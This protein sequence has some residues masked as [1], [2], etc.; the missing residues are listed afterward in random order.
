MNTGIRCWHL[1]TKVIRTKKQWARWLH[2]HVQS[3]PPLIVVGMMQHGQ[4][5]ITA[6]MDWRVSVSKAAT[7]SACIAQ[8]PSS[9]AW[10]ILSSPV[11][12]GTRSTALALGLSPGVAVVQCDLFP[13]LS[14]VSSPQLYLALT[15]LMLLGLCSL[16][17]N[18]LRT[19][20]GPWAKNY[21]TI[22][23]NKS[24][25]SR[26]LFRNS[27]LKSEVKKKE[28]GKGQSGK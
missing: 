1:V 12:Y 10:K 24:V 7:N 4:S 22:L 18:S 5:S 14:V 19:G 23:R 8:L 16:N 17:V 13:L 15:S 6:R 2:L 11:S 28:N 26:A 9:A 20:H 3:V 27:L 21:S 25:K